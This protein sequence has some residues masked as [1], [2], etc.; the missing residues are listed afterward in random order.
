M[1]RRNK[2]FL[3]LSLFALAIPTGVLAADWFLGWNAWRWQTAGPRQNAQEVHRLY[4]L[5]EFCN[6]SNILEKRM[7]F[8]IQKLR[9]KGAY[10]NNRM[11]RWESGGAEPKH[12]TIKMGRGTN[13]SV[14]DQDLIEAGTQTSP[15]V[16]RRNRQIQNLRDRNST[17]L[18]NLFGEVT[19]YGAEDPALW[20]AVQ[21]K[22][23]ELTQILKT[24]E[25]Q[26]C[27]AELDDLLAGR[28]KT[29]G[30]R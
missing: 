3:V 19:K 20:G 4:Q 26:G 24:G 6:Q 27:M 25:F 8:A 16:I 28:A 9:D 21:A 13:P 12:L 29:G 17:Y 30:R 22:Q 1:R 5:R 15:L 2:R 10:W 18:E 23:D 14:Y 11:A 7:D